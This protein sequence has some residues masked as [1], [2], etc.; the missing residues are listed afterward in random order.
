M[1]P[2]RIPET[3]DHGGAPALTLPAP[4]AIKPIVPRPPRR[5]DSA[6]SANAATGAAEQNRRRVTPQA[7]ASQ[8]TAPRAAEPDKR[9]PLDL[10]LRPQ[11]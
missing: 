9:A 10:L 7:S 8:P 1:R 5:T 2:G 4:M 6:N 11:N 3:I